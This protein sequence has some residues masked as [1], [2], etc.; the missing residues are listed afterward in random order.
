MGI[1]WR[2]GATG[3]AV[4]VSLGFGP[5]GHAE[6]EVP[7]IRAVLYNDAGSAPEVVSRAERVVTR[8]FSEIGVETVW[9]DIDE[10][11]RETPTEPAARLAF[12]ARVIVVRL[13]SAP[14]SKDSGFKA[15]SLGAAAPGTRLAR[16]CAGCVAALARIDGVEQGDLLGYVIVH[17]L[18]HLLLPPPAHAG[19]GV[20]QP[21]VDLQLIQHNRVAFLP[22]QATLIRAT[23]TEL[24]EHAAR[25]AEESSAS[26]NLC[27]RRY[28]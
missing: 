28:C 3:L 21:G 10:F 27:A 5:I 8:T 26:A 17:E 12:V 6:A 22:Q 15:D 9:L 11:T 13:V 16:I 7:K 24:I 1:N 25:V 2:I 23:L 18:G 20:M 14:K 19:T 4:A